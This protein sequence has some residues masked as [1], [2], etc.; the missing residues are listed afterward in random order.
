MDKLTPKQEKFCINYI[1][2]DSASD[3]YRASYNTENCTNKSIWESASRLLASNK[4]AS[5]IDELK[6]A[7]YERHAIT[8]DSIAKELE[9]ARQ[10]AKDNQIPSAM[11]QASMGKA[12]LFG[13]IT[14]KKELSGGIQITHEQALREIE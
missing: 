4:V 11:I 13:L 9:E 2:L 10:L 14:D 5:R 3:A 6:A 7:H 12:K 1:E 8:V